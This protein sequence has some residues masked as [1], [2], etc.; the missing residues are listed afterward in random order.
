MQVICNPTHNYFSACVLLMHFAEW[1]LRCPSFSFP[2]KPIS[3]VIIT[4][5]EHLASRFAPACHISIL[6]ASQE[7]EESFF[8]WCCN[9]SQHSHLLHQWTLC[10]CLPA[11][12]SLPA[13]ATY[14]S[15]SF[16][17][18]A[19][20]A[21]FTAISFSS[22]LPFWRKHT[23]ITCLRAAGWGRAVSLHTWWCL[24][25]QYMWSSES[26]PCQRKAPLSVYNSLLSLWQ[27]ENKADMRG[28]LWRRAGSS[29]FLPTQR[30]W[31]WK[32]LGRRQDS[33][34]YTA[35]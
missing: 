20:C 15:W 6:F 18:S 13:P 23:L 17:P 19:V 10:S 29:V 24:Q 25:P 11:L 31:W 9:L 22:F 32:T 2:A 4:P 8:S 3:T 16:I 27:Q 7:A 12:L 33:D 30:W 5:T 26:I 1:K 35:P 34:Q 21:P 14:L 28:R